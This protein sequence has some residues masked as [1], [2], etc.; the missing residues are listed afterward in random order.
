ME[1]VAFLAY[2][3]IELTTPVTNDTMGEWEGVLACRSVG[4]FLKG[5]PMG[6]GT[7]RKKAKKQVNLLGDATDPTVFGV[8][9]QAYQMEKVCTACFEGTMHA[10]VDPAGNMMPGLAGADG[11][12]R[13]VMHACTV[14][15]T[16]QALALPP[17]P[18]PNMVPAI[19]VEQAAKMVGRNAA[20]ALGVTGDNIIPMP[21]VQHPV[22]PEAEGG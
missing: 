3:W 8:P 12:A 4:H 19:P 15:G 21:G 17:W 14:C 20:V 16:T 22:S 5:V 18:R 9:V 6:K 13:T 7:I 11:Q 2:L 10:K 1:P